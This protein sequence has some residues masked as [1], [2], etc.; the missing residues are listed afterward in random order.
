MP[1]QETRKQRRERHSR[2][3]EESQQKLRANIAETERLLSASDEILK[4]HRRE[5]DEDGE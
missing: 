4:R 2:E 5:I 1:R 3:I